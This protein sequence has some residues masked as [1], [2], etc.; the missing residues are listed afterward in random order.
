[1]DE[2]SG[3]VNSRGFVTELLISGF[4]CSDDNFWGFV[5]GRVWG[6][7]PTTMTTMMMMRLRA[8]VG[9]EVVTRWGDELVGQ[10]EKQKKKKVAIEGRVD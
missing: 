1:M 6:V 9:A 10:R 5:R 3:T 7:P 2:Q 8:F 4:G